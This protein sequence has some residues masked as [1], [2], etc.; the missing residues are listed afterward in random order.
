[1]SRPETRLG[2]RFFHPLLLL[3]VVPPA[4]VLHVLTQARDGVVLLVPVRHF[5]HG[6]V[7]RAVVRGAVVSD[8]ATTTLV[9][10][11]EIKTNAASRFTL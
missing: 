2:S 10:D 6:S 1:M 5:V 7:G 9:Q 8:S 4:F 11:F 3:L